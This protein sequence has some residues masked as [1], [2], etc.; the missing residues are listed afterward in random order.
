[1]RILVASD[2]V[3]AGHQGTAELSAADAAAAIRTG[4]L[5]AS[6]DDDVRAIAVSKPGGPGLVEAVHARRGGDLRTT[7]VPGFLGEPT[8]VSFCLAEGVAYVDAGEVIGAGLLP[9]EQGGGDPTPVP[10][11]VERASSRGMGE[12]LTHVIDAGA[13]RIVVWLADGGANDA[14]AGLLAGLGARSNPDDALTG[15]PASL[16]TLDNVDL[17]DA[18]A[19]TAEVDLVVATDQNLPLLGLRGTTNL[20]GVARGLEEDRK[21]AV[22]A[23]LERFAAQVDPDLTTRRGAGAGGGVGYGLLALGARLEP[24]FATL[25]DTLGLRTEARMAEVVLVGHGQLSWQSLPGSTLAGVAGLAEE[26]VRPCVALARTVEVGNRELRANGIEAAYAA[27]D[28]IDDQTTTF[29][30][31]AAL[32]ALAERVARTWSRS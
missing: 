1:M 12:L 24:G 6:P 32:A 17:S 21:V 31:E 13:S 5:R 8:P 9:H 15:G 25:A 14:G 7:T 2:A 20:H 27:T 28:T 3:S 10:G 26:V 22:D 29:D 18:R 11:L 30:P 19:L 4:W 23:T 16:D